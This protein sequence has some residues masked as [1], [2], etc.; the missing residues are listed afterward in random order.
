MKNK[1]SIGII[2]GLT[3][4]TIVASSSS[5][6]SIAQTETM[7]GLVVRLVGDARV[8]S[9]RGKDWASLK[10]GDWIAPSDLVQTAERSDL[11]I[12][13][14]EKVRPIAPRTWHGAP[15]DPLVRPSN[16]LHLSQ[17]TVLG[18]LRADNASVSAGKEYEE[19]YLQLYT[20][21]ITGSVKGPNTIYEIKTTNGAACI[22]TN[23]IYTMTGS[24]MFKLIMGTA[25]VTTGKQSTVNLFPMQG[26]DFGTGQ[27]TNLPPLDENWSHDLWLPSEPGYIHWADPPRI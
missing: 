27:Q 5:C 10:L 2:V 7:K 22:K 11:Y 23:A 19:I 16:L 18:V 21:D 15:F 6:R 4:V 20:G 14:G 3:T 9:N 12:S 26:V 24:G 17:N 13:F 1:C 25:E 8:S